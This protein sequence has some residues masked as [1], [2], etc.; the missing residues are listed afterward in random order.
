MNTKSLIAAVTLAVVLVGVA[1]SSAE[2]KTNYPLNPIGLIKNAQTGQFQALIPNGPHPNFAAPLTLQ[3]PTGPVC[4]HA[5]NQITR[6]PGPAILYC[7]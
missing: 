3:P 2:A 6:R 5:V 1:A 4:V 7:K